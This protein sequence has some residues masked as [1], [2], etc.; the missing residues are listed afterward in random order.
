[1]SNESN[2]GRELVMKR[3]R[4]A[5]VCAE[6]GHEMYGYTNK[7]YC[8][9]TCRNRVARRRKK[10]QRLNEEKRDL[11]KRLAQPSPTKSMLEHFEDS[12]SKN[13]EL[14]RLLGK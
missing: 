5:S 7:V 2:P 9:A 1:M 14:Y 8:G 11:E 6:C 10:E 4:R 12:L 3:K 13:Q